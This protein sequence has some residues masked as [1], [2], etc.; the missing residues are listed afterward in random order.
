MKLKVMR[1]NDINIRKHNIP[2]EKDLRI[3]GLNSLI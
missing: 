3:Q 2:P 1:K